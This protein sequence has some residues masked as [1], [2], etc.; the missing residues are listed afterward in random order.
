MHV[1]EIFKEKFKKITQKC[2]TKY[3][4]THNN[5]A[6]WLRSQL[7]LILQPHLAYKCSVKKSGTILY[8]HGGDLLPF[9]VA[10]GQ[11]RNLTQQSRNNPSDQNL[12]RYLT[13]TCYSLNTQTAM[14]ALKS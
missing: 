2:D 12:E 11:V 1:Y 9:N 5:S 10:L 4:T 6:T 3:S 13:E 8:R 7:S 14:P